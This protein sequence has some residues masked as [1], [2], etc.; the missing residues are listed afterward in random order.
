MRT[1]GPKFKKIV[2]EETIKEL[3]KRDKERVDD[4]RKYEGLEEEIIYKLP[5]KMLEIWEG[6]DGE[7]REIIEETLLSSSQ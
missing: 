2:K 4:M 7:I 5:N 3:K 1:I 6:A